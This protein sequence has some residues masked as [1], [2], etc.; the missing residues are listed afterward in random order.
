[1]I[2]KTWEYDGKKVSHVSRTKYTSVFKVLFLLF[3]DPF[4]VCTYWINFDN[5]IEHFS[6]SLLQSWSSR[7]EETLNFF[8]DSFDAHWKWFDWSTEEEE[9]ETSEVGFFLVVSIFFL[10]S[11][12]SKQICR[13]KFR[14]LSE[15]SL[16]SDRMRNGKKDLGLATL[17]TIQMWWRW[18]ERIVLIATPMPITTTTIT[19]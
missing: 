13:I 3:L 16:S 7:F 15:Y 10:L 8:F 1:M 14:F 9:K 11:F 17:P 4:I 2:E 12:K 18:A 5:S 6:L 19:S